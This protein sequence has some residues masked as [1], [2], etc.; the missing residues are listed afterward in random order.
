MSSNLKDIH[1]GQ[2]A[3]SQG[4]IDAAKADQAR[5]DALTGT[6]ANIYGTQ[7]NKKLGLA[8]VN[9][10]KALQLQLQEQELFRKAANDFTTAVE[11][12]FNH[13]ITDSS[14]QFEFQGEAGRIKAQQQAYADVWSKLPP[15][16]QMML[17][18]GSNYNPAGEKAPVVPENATI[19]T[20]GAAPAAPAGNKAMP[21][22][23]GGQLRW[24]P[25]A[26]G[27]QGALV[28]IR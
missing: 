15:R 22:T 10:T 11:K 1:A 6:I 20:P 4:T 16:S 25:T 14:K 23:P 5:Q 28:S 26:N 12:R 8:Q 18:A 9:A 24:D 7:E 3:L 2:K 17:Q 21:V 19:A 27:G 13:L